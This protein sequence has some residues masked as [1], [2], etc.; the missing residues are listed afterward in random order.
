MI[1]LIQQGLGSDPLYDEST[2]SDK[3]YVTED[4]DAAFEAGKNGMLLFGDASYT[5][6]VSQLEA[7]HPAPE[8]LTYVRK[9]YHGNKFDRDIFINKVPILEWAF[10]LLSAEDLIE[11]VK[12]AG[13]C[14]V[15]TDEWTKFKGATYGISR[16]WTDKHEDFYVRDLKHGPFY[17]QAISYSPSKAKAKRNRPVSN[18]IGKYRRGKIPVAWFNTFSF[19]LEDLLDFNMRMNKNLGTWDNVESNFPSIVRTLKKLN[20]LTYL[21]DEPRYI[22]M[23]EEAS[24][25]VIGANQHRVEEWVEEWCDYIKLECDVLDLPTKCYDKK[26]KKG[27][28]CQTSPTN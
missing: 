14:W 27:N 1:Y 15:R 13:T 18:K 16:F 25:Y 24:H 3:Y 23:I 10:E 9:G 5:E 8:G 21:R 4:P 20:L 6:V 26:K 11:L 2:Y 12:D 17:Y 28:S 7:H 19:R 22:E